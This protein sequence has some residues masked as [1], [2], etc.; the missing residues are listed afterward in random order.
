MSDRHMRILRH[1]ASRRQRDLDQ[2]DAADHSGE[3]AAADHLQHLGDAATRTRGQVT[4]AEQRREPSSH[5]PSPPTRRA[6]S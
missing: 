6:T 4:A 3:A 1:I 2:Y 5:E